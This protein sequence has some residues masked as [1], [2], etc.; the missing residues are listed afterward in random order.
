MGLIRN[1]IRPKPFAVNSIKGIKSIHE[2]ALP[3]KQFIDMRECIDTFEPYNRNRTYLRNYKF[4]FKGFCSTRQ[5]LQTRERSGFKPQYVL[6]DGEKL[7]RMRIC[8]W[9]TS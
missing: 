7:K 6:T 5:T 2:C 1:S 4:H 9:E 3:K 8:N